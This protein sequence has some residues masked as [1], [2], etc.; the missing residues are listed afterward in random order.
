M[1]QKDKQ[2]IEERKGRQEAEAKYTQEKEKLEQELQQ[3]LA[4]VA[5]REQFIITCFA[6][7]VSC[8]NADGHVSEEEVEELK[9][10]ALGVSKTDLLTS[11]NK[12]LMDEMIANPPSL[13]TVLKM[14]EDHGF[15]SSKYTELFSQIIHV[16]IAADDRTDV[17][18]TQFL[19]EWNAAAA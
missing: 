10:F 4:E 17:Q 1:K 9:Y 19:K 3:M 11:T 15:N 8:A 6:L 2:K 14:I 7:G 5:N 18:E 13:V 12:S 16:V